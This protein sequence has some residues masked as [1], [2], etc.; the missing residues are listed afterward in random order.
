MAARQDALLI[1]LK[2][3]L[4][5]STYL[6]NPSALLEPA[7]NPYVVKHEHSSFCS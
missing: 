2:S 3:Y 4:P 1:R 6:S 7:E 5:N